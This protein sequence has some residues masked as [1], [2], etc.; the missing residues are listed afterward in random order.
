MTRTNTEHVAGMTGTQGDV[1]RTKA[2]P[3]RDSYERRT[4]PGTHWDVTRTKVD[5]TRA[6][7]ARVR[8][9]L[10]RLASDRKP[11]LPEELQRTEEQIT[12][13]ASDPCTFVG[14]RICPLS[15]VGTTQRYFI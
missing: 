15:R 3:G 13:S 5:E 12:M 2:R 8:A 4:R 14:I 11:T 1:T 10:R 7:R 6:W 9:T